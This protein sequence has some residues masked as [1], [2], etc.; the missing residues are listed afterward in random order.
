MQLFVVL[1]ENMS[2]GD[3]LKKLREKKGLS[4]PAFAS[5]IGVSFQ[6]VQHWERG[7]KKP[8]LNRHAAIAEILGVDPHWITDLCAKG[9]S[10]EDSP[11]TEI[12]GMESAEVLDSGSGIGRE[13]GARR[14]PDLSNHMR[15][16]D[17]EGKYLALSPEENEFVKQL[18]ALA[19]RVLSSNNIVVREA[20]RSNII[21]FS[22]DLARIYEI[23]DLTEEQ[24]KARKEQIKTNKRL[25]R[26]EDIIVSLPVKLDWND[27][28]DD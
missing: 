9:E 17:R 7:D 20:L 25:R 26:L 10:K 12:T 27:H 2:F 16:L 19:A 13:E 14:F 21:A 11:P 1:N 6:A 22:E 23:E 3:E 8:R 18:L 4:Q 5:L 15:K 24:I 28:E